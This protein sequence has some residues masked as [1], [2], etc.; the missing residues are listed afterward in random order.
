MIKAIF[1]DVDDTIL[2]FVAFTKETMEIGFREFGLPPYQ[3]G[4]YAVFEQV[5]DPL[6]HQLERG[7]ITREQLFRRRWQGVLDA[8]GFQ[9]DGWAFERYFRER[10]MRTVHP[11]EG[12]DALIPW[13]SARYVLCAASNASA[14]QQETRLGLAGYL[15]CFHHLFISERLGAQKP[16]A[17]FF[18]RCLEQ[19]NER[20]MPGVEYP[21]Q[22]REILMVGDSL[23]SDIRGGAAAGLQTCW[24]NRFDHKKPDDLAIDHII[25][26]LD[27]LPAILEA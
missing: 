5:N 26:R 7:E 6:W 21:I 18:A 23:S 24:F 12:A 19:L 14:V 2:D 22:P 16:T 1:L 11:V 4:M 9:A 3:E 17:E 20:Q 13:L 10:L 15:P 27:E 8:L 25:R